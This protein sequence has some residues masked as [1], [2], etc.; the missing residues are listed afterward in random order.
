M[1]ILGKKLAGQLVLRIFSR[2][3]VATVSFETLLQNLDNTVTFKC[4]LCFCRATAA[5]DGLK[6]AQYALKGVVDHFKKRQKEFTVGCKDLLVEHLLIIGGH[7][8]QLKKNDMCLFWSDLAFQIDSSCT[9]TSMT[10]YLSLQACSC[11]C[12]GIF[13]LALEKNLREWLLQNLD[14]WTT[15]I[16]RLSVFLMLPLPRESTRFLSQSTGRIF[17]SLLLCGGRKSSLGQRLF[18][19]LSSALWRNQVSRRFDCFLGSP[20]NAIMILLFLGCRVRRR[21]DLNEVCLSEMCRHVAKYCRNGK[22][23][24]HDVILNWV[25]ILSNLSVEQKSSIANVLTGWC[26]Y[27]FGRYGGSE[28]NPLSIEPAEPSTVKDKYLLRPDPAVIR[29]I[30]DVL[31]RECRH[32]GRNVMATEIEDAFK[33]WPELDSIVSK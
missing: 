22:N 21:E 31:V 29:K 6:E 23:N 26:A 7:C 17:A 20:R 13:R 33:T 24:I 9:D 3:G 12:K 15:W 27:K 30:I 11:A 10:P 5:A 4:A 16:G 1:D 32:Y 2:Y 28:D 18:R 25:Y 19:C 8:R 14:I